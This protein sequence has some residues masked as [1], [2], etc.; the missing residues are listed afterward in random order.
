MFRTLLITLI[1]CSSSYAAEI[2]NYR[3]ATQNY[4]GNQQFV[5]KI[6]VS[7]DE[8]SMMKVSVSKG[9]RTNSRLFTFEEEEV[10]QERLNSFVFKLLKR[11]IT[12]LSN[13][14]VT[15][16][17]SQIICMMMPGPGQSTDHLSVRRAYDFTA[18]EFTG[19]MELI[20]SP[21]GCWISRKIHPEAQRDQNRGNILKAKLETLA[22]RLIG[23]EL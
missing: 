13:A 16:S 6:T 17:H 9:S 12:H 8:D 18:D 19:Q 14:K 22:L 11:D 5:N 1:L 4:S 10:S 21:T 23:Q 15:T 3:F 7:V 20:Y 2:A